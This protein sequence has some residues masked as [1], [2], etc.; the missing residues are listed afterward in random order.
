MLPHPAL[1]LMVSS[2]HMALSSA[3]RTKE[4]NLLKNRHPRAHMLSSAP[5]IFPRY[6]FL[7]FMVHRSVQPS[8]VDPHVLFLEQVDPIVSA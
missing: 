1:F 5:S 3:E 4:R 2:R 6:L 8:L 7:I